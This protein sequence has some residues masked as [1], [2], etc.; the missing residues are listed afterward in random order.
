MGNINFVSDYMR[1]LRRFNYSAHT[2]KNYSNVLENFVRWLRVPIES[3]TS[4]E[5]LKYIDFLLDKGLKSKTVSSYLNCIR[6][7]Y[8]FLRDEVGMSI[9]NPVKPGYTLR[10]PSPLP[11][12][13]V[14][15]QIEL[16][17]DAMNNRRDEAM[18]RLM[19]RCGLR[20]G[21][22]AHLTLGAIDLQRRRITVHCGKWCRD[23]IV[24]V[25][26]DAN[27]ALKAYLDSRPR[28]RSKN[29]FLL[30]RELSKTRR[31]QFGVS[32]RGLNIK[33]KKQG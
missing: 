9:P 15:E 28:T 1:L 33:P 12:F 13:L 26:D 21:E 4:V 10:L 11:R 7:F 30:K 5:V 3:V 31:Y 24:F 6:G 29:L 17:F 14:D 27:Q 8:Q 19:L 18:F 32:K 22:V 16:L 25:S 2:I 20:V 23:R